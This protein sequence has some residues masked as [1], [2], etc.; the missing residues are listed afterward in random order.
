MRMIRERKWEEKVKK[1]DKQ[2]CD[3]VFG[4]EGGKRKRREMRGEIVV[5]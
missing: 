4:K 2:K 5:P 3:I 1:K